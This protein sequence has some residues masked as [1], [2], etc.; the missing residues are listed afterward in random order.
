MRQLIT[1]PLWVILLASLVIRRP[2]MITT[3]WLSRYAALLEELYQVLPVPRTWFERWAVATIIGWIDR[4]KAAA[5]KL[6]QIK[7]VLLLF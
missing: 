7:A 5:L 2:K 6:V 3:I 4:E 1:F